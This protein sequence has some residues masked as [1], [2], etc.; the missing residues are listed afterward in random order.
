MNRPGGSSSSS[1]PSRYRSFQP[2]K[3]VEV[4]ASQLPD[5]LLIQ[6]QP[7]HLPQLILGHLR[8]APE[9][10]LRGD[11]RA[12]HR[13]SVA[14][15]FLRHR[16]RLELSRYPVPRPRHQPLRARL[17]TQRPHRRRHAQT[18]GRSLRRIRP[19]APR[20]RSEPHRGTP[21]RP[22]RLVQ[23]A[24]RD[25]VRQNVSRRR[26]LIPARKHLERRHRLVRV[27]RCRGDLD[28]GVP[29]NRDRQRPGSGLRPEGPGRRGHPGAVAQRRIGI[30]AASRVR[31]ESHRRA[32][33]R[34]PAL[35]QN[36]HDHRLRQRAAAPRPLIPSRKHLERRHRL[37]RVHGGG[38]DFD[39]G[40]AIRRG[41]QHLPT[42]LRPQRPLHHRQPRAVAANLPGCD[43]AAARLRLEPHRHLRHRCATRIQHAHPS[44]FKQRLSR[45]RALPVPQRLQRNGDL[46][47]MDHGLVRRL[48]IRCV[49]MRRAPTGR[50]HGATA[51]HHEHQPIPAPP[52]HLARTRRP[53]AAY[54]ERKPLANM[55][56]RHRVRHDLKR[57][58]RPHRT[59]FARPQHRQAQSRH[60]HNRRRAPRPPPLA[61]RGLG[62]RGSAHQ[63]DVHY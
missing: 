40:H 42:R 30:R 36:S 27:H 13:G 62:S 58:L 50:R 3:P 1:L 56:E 44:R 15:P 63:A 48:Q 5:A 37:V 31:L 60:D 46:A 43:P 41:H 55:G 9:P 25:G 23:Y 52:P 7:F 47:H 34:P 21:D 51:V 61:P 17:R 54:R 12:H 16:R 32:R 39:I 14:H 24:H 20:V 53:A 10:Q 4:A 35:V 26:P 57:R 22:P 18:V 28:P 8:A 59:V 2:D 45:N 33:D 11:L 19:P 6:I 49:H 38:H 29:S